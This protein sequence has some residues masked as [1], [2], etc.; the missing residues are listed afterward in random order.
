MFHADL[1][2]RLGLIPMEILREGACP[3]LRMAKIGRNRSSD[4]SRHG[5]AMK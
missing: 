1:C 2:Q 4:F 5:L 3:S